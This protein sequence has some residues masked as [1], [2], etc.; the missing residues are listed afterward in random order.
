[1]RSL[2]CV[3]ASLAIGSAVAAQTSD[4]PW[5]EQAFIGLSLR[6][7]DA[8]PVVSW[9]RPG[10]LGGTGFDSASGVRRGDNFVAL[11]GEAM[12]AEAFGAAIRAAEPGTRVTLTFRRSPEASAG[13]AI[14]Q[15]GEGGET[16][17]IACE[18]SDRATWSGTV[19]RGLGPRELP[20]APEGAFE[21]QILDDAAARG[22]ADH[23]AGLAALMVSIAGVQ[24][25]AY[26]PL[27]LPAVV[28]ALERPL[29]LDAAEA[30]IA[31]QVNKLAALSAHPADDDLERI[32]TLVRTTLDLP[33]ETDAGRIEAGVEA[34]MR[35]ADVP[36]LAAGL[37]EQM[38]TDWSIQTDAAADHLRVIRFA[39]EH[40]RGVV[41]RALARMTDGALDWE[42]TCASEPAR[43]LDESELP[44]GFRDAVTG[45]VCRVRTDADGRWAV[46]GGDGPNTYDTSRVS[47]V[48]DTGGNDRYRPATLRRH[49]RARPG[50]IRR[51]S[52]WRAMTCTR[53]IG[54]WPG[55][56]RPSSGL[57]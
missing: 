20:E 46:H 39:G 52:I 2:L 35:E 49:A 53:Q 9:V 22:I 55:R 51:S 36:R 43:V 28:H 23:P 48:Y 15:G 12:D 34:A 6:Q 33:A 26:D 56:R 25:E 13:G 11:N 27:A 37:V 29:S 18:L 44:E 57:R 31:E 16:F 47:F 14:A 24:A 38:R 30:S 3:A 32:A 10:P 50:L 8:G 1:M 45:D 4:T 41:S 40:A 54:R 19:G 5:E 21:R 42:R 17:D 7:T